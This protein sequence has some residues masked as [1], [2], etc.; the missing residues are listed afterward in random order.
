MTKIELA[1]KHL[2][3]ESNDVFGIREVSAHII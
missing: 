3:G 1:M 2:C